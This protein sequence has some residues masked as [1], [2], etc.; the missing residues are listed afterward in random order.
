MKARYTLK[1]PARI[2]VLGNPTDANEGDFHTI[3]AAITIFAGGLI[4]PAEKLTFDFLQKGDVDNPLD[5]ITASVGQIPFKHDDK[6]KLFKAAVSHMLMFY[7]PLKMEMEKTKVRIGIW[8]E[9]PRQSGL[10]GSSIIILLILNALKEFYDL[11]KTEFNDYVLAELTQRI[12]EID[13]GITCGFSDRYIAQMGG[14]AYMDYRGKLFHKNIFD[15]PFA[16]YERLNA[17]TK[18]MR[19][20]V[21]S[22]GV[23]R[24]SGSVHSVLR[25][26]YLL[27]YRKKAT[28][29]D[30]KSQI[31]QKFEEVAKTAWVGKILLLRGDL[32]AF[33]D[34]MNKNHRLVNEIMLYCGFVGGAGEANNILIKAAL[35]NGALGAKLTG[36]GGGG[37]V[38]AL[39]K[40]RAEKQVFNAMKGAAEKAGLTDAK[41]YRVAIA[42]KGV[43]VTKEGK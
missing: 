25:G 29:P 36:A 19:F 33:G 14:L 32:E 22:S 34:L 43:R 4:E 24:E 16:T 6:F 23:M 35:D 18:E 21:A 10:A 12:E 11:P 27:E 39:V 7:P 42:D 28:Y 26:R 1:I 5:S 8:T 40:P 9:V 37:S 38:F 2:N 15:E 31:L 13:L 17:P 30:Y 3:S 20:I 41:F